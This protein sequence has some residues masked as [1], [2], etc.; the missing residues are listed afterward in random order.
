MKRL[1]VTEVERLSYSRK[2]L[3]A[4]SALRNAGIDPSIYGM[5]KEYR[6]LGV[7]GK[8]YL[9]QHPDGTIYHFSRLADIHAYAADY[10]A[11]QQQHVVPDWQ[12]WRARF[13]KDSL[14]LSRCA[15]DDCPYQAITRFPDETALCAGHAFIYERMLE[16]RRKR[17][18]RVS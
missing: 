17:Q 2:K 11:F 9:V 15:W 7:K 3:R 10:Q 8:V 4:I 16:E 13:Q 5:H 18:Q 14:P 6:E 1:H 12:Q